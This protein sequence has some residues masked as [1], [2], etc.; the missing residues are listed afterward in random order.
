MATTNSPKTNT[1]LIE[2]HSGKTAPKPFP[3]FPTTSSKTSS[4]S[5]E[6]SVIASETAP[7]A[8]DSLWPAESRRESSSSR[9]SK[10][11]DPN[12]PRWAAHPA[13]QTTVPTG[14]SNAEGTV[15]YGTDPGAA[16]DLH[17]AW[18]AE[19]GLE[20]GQQRAHPGR[21]LPRFREGARRSY[22]VILLV[23]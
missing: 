12:P 6:I 15:F 2:S 11:H 3:D 14:T 13:E 17:A 18:A 10:D 16:D 19:D 4:V 23:L 5:G 22:A 1:G 8:L 9:L 7:E 21:D 20:E